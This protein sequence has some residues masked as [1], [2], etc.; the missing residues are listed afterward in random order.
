MADRI[1]RGRVL[2]F[3]AEPEGPDD[4]GAYLYEEDGAV[5]VRDGRIAGVGSFDAV[6]VRAGEAEVIDHRPHLILPGFI[7]P[8]IHFPQLQ[9]IA[10]WGA[11]LLEWLN[12][13][14]FPAEAE[15]ADPDH[16]R[17]MAGVFLD[18]LL[19]HGTTSAAAFCS[20]HAA[21]VEA[22]FGAAE[23]RGMCMIAG[24]VMMDRNAPD[25]LRDTARR[26]YDQS[27]AL[28]TKWHGRGRLR[29]A[30]TPRFAL[31]SSPVQLNA[32]GALV[33]EF[34][35]C[36]MQTH[37]SENPD[38]IAAVAGMYPH[39]RDYLDVYESH[40]LIGPKALLGHCIHLTDRE[41]ARIVETGARPVFCPTSN[42][43]LGSGLFDRCR[44]RGA[45]TGIATDVGAGTSFSMLQTLGDA[46]KIGQLQ[47]QALHP[48]TAFHWATRGNAVAL[49]LEDRI[50][51][52]AEGS[53]A[54]LV[55]LDPRATPEMALRHGR[56]ESLSDELFMLMVMGDG[57]SVAGTYV[58]GA[59]V[60]RAQG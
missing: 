10:S 60:A 35:D 25:A 31:T 16:A 34:P 12:D 21:S 37:M 15:F 38:E 3:H 23:A 50:G 44:L 52:M 53:D 4:T 26:G 57:R 13:Y 40:G 17:A 1:L 14:V 9:V 22:L 6:A 20:V 7:D 55:V 45:V 58:A 42:L 46:Y 19:S 59:S 36:H 32:A 30:V 18:L 8:H 29:Y 28:I 48:L 54:D 56:V 27:R 51:T 47:G 49:G 11:Q 33:A 43:F 39:A 24:K 41:V 5:W 2:D